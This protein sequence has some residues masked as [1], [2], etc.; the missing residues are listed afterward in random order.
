MK[1]I[2]L[3]TVFSSE[4]RDVDFFFESVFSFPFNQY[5]KEEFQDHI[6]VVFLV[7]WGNSTLLSIV[8]LSIYILTN[9]IDRVLFSVYSYQHLLFLVFFFHDGHSNRYEEISS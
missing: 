6:L 5:P 1:G 3:H 8:A 4:Y 2:V 7:F 9:S